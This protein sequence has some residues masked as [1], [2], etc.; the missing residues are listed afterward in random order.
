[1]AHMSLHSTSD[2]HYSPFHNQCNVIDVILDQEKTDTRR[3]G[4]DEVV[5]I[6]HFQQVDV[7]VIRF[8]T[9]RKGTFNISKLL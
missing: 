1:M 5:P 6:G 7:I 2:R 9:G 3:L 4:P 8:I